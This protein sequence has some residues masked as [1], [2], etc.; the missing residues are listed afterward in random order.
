MSMLVLTFELSKNTTT[1]QNE[2]HVDNFAGD[3]FWL[4]LVFSCINYLDT[5]WYRKVTHVKNIRA[6]LHK[7]GFTDKIKNTHHNKTNTLFASLRI[8][9]SIFVKKK[10]KTIVKQNITKNC[11]KRATSNKSV[12]WYEIRNEQQIGKE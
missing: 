6:L 3:F 9:K 5:I 10:R 12:W 7:K 2:Y 4:F 8:S 1:V 11:F